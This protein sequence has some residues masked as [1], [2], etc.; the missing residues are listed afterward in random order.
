MRMVFQCW[1]QGRGCSHRHQ[2]CQPITHLLLKKKKGCHTTIVSDPISNKGRPLMKESYTC[3][4]S[5]SLASAFFLAHFYGCTL[6]HGLTPL[7]DRSHFHEVA[8]AFDLGFTSARFPLALF[9]FA[10]HLRCHSDSDSDSS[11]IGFWAFT[12]FALLFMDS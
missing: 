1:K 12:R 11:A 7:M 10:Y 3:S 5:H 2:P 6:A 4:T 8:L 9:T